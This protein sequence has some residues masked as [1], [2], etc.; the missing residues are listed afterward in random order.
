[1]ITKFESR[2]VLTIYVIVMRLI[3]DTTYTGEI[4]VEIYTRALHRELVLFQQS[5]NCFRYV[6][7][8]YI[9]GDI[10]A[11]TSSIPT[12]DGIMWKV[13]WLR[14]HMLGGWNWS[15][16]RSIFRHGWPRRLGERSQTQRSGKYGGYH[17]VR[18]QIGAD[19]CVMCM[20]D[21]SP[22]P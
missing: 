4:Q 21:G 6:P 15:W 17:P 16:E 3:F 18:V 7:D 19:S 11:C 10:L 20:L 13:R 8:N 12:V 22:P 5:R 2:C 1:M 9:K 14:E